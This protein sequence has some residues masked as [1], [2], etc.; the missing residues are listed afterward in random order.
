MSCITGD[1]EAG[2]EK[3]IVE[4]VDIRGPFGEKDERSQTEM[5]EESALEHQLQWRCSFF[6]ILP[7]TIPK[8]TENYI[9]KCLKSW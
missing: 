7:P 4:S 3:S 9:L 1:P 2:Y 8:F 6:E 5:T